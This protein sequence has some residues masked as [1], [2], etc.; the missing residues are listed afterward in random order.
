MSESF[1][2]PQGDKFMGAI[3]STG[4]RGKTALPLLSKRIKLLNKVAGLNIKSAFETLKNRDFNFKWF[5]FKKL[6]QNPI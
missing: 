2:S 3:D 1:V 5:S 4:N 6:N